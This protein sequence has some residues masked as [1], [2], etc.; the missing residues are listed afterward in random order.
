[1]GDGIIGVA[2]FDMKPK[3]RP[4]E[5]ERA[6][7]AIG[8]DQGYVLVHKGIGFESELEALGST[9]TDDLGIE[10]PKKPMGGLVVFTCRPSWT[11]G[12]WSH[13]LSDYDDVEVNFNKEASFRHPTEEEQK[14]INAGDYE[15]LVELWTDIP[16]PYEEE[17]S[18]PP[19]KE[20]T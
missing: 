5:L 1:M 13:G 2:K 18:D 4:V 11:G 15:K 12:N 16:H 20:G 14:L 19:V 9:H 17:A 10:F 6:L 7:I 8:E 3:K